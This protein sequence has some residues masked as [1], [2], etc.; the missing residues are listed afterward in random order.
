MDILTQVGLP[1]ISLTLMLFGLFSL[2]FVPI[3]PSLVVMWV[4]P[5]LFGLLDGFD[6]PASL[7]LFGVITLLMVA[8]SLV[9]N[10][11]MGAGARSSGASWS[12]ITLALLAGMLGSLFLP[13]FG[14][15]LLSLAALFALEYYRQRSWRSALASTKNMALGC[16]WAVVARFALG[17][18]MIALYL[19]WVFWA[20]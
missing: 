1:L 2:I 3:L 5:L 16:G 20:R 19:G 4:G 12:T 17:L 15:I 10:L 18:V 13:L 6:T 7:V 11:L 14:G 9:D 8:G